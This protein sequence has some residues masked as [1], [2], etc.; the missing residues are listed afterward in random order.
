MKKH[1]SGFT[2]IELVIVIVILGILAITLLPSYV[3]LRNEAQQAAVEGV[4]GSLG[5]SSAVNFAARTA[6]VAKGVAVA[7]CTDVSAALQGGA[8]S[9][10][11]GYT[12]T[13]TAISAGAATSCTVTGPTPTSATATFVGLGIA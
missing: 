9:L 2:L 8:S 5:G 4:A 13:S 12:V 6:N 7:N 3:D 1:Q 10:P 11:S